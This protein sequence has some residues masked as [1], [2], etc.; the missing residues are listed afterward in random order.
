MSPC[1]SHTL[2]NLIPPLGLG[3][4][5]LSQATR[6]RNPPRPPDLTLNLDID[7]ARV[8]TIK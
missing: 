5:A 6:A 8:T 7:R 4:W 2:E 1:F 3:A